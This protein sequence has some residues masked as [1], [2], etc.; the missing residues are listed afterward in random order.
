MLFWSFY[1]AVGGGAS[2]P[3]FHA[4]LLDEPGNFARHIRSTILWQQHIPKT[5]STLNST[6][7]IATATVTATATLTA[8]ATVTSTAT[9]TVTKHRSQQPSIQQAVTFLC[10]PNRTPTWVVQGIHQKNILLVPS[11][12]HCHR[13]PS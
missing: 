8:T 9:L 10:H 6:V 11:F 2:L 1:E 3:S 12:C 5:N 7:T 4:R 13:Q